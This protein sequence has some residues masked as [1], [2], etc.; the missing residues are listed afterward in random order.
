MIAHLKSDTTTSSYEAGSAFIVLVIKIANRVRDR[1]I[2]I[3]LTLHRPR[4]PISTNC[5]HKVNFLSWGELEMFASRLPGD[6]RP[7]WAATLNR[8]KS[9]FSEPRLRARFDFIVFIRSSNHIS[10]SEFQYR[11]QLNKECRSASE[12]YGII[13]YLNYSLTHFQLF[14]KKYPQSNRPN[15]RRSFFFRVRLFILVPNLKNPLRVV[16]S[17]SS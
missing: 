8:I 14:R 4:N 12:H 17:F 5:W 13:Y 2:I 9:H 1:A 11:R 7:N 6:K 10:L 16:M 15:E 3:N